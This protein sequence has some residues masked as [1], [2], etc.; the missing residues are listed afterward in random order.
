M[1]RTGGAEQG[2]QSASGRSR[3]LIGYFPSDTVLDGC[4]GVSAALETEWAAEPRVSAL[5]RVS[6][7]SRNGMYWDFV[8][9]EEAYAVHVPGKSIP[10][11]MSIPTLGPA[12]LLVVAGLI[13]FVGFRRVRA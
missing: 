1:R 12:G 7:L 3:V 4:V 10:T 6:I 8:E 11:G 9:L 13:G 2:P 5:Q